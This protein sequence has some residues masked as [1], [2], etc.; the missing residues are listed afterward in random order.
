MRESLYETANTDIR[1]LYFILLICI[2]LHTS[3][4]EQLK[5]RYINTGFEELN[6]GHK[7]HRYKKDREGLV[8]DD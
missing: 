2:E 1:P 3:N 4:I 6:I 5:P 7:L 8:I